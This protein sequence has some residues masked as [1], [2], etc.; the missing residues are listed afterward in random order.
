MRVHSEFQLAVIA[1]KE[2]CIYTGVQTKKGRGVKMV[3][4]LPTLYPDYRC[5]V[6]L[7]AAPG[8]PTGNY[9]IASC[10]LH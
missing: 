4:N 8:M 7:T 10:Q 3:V 1:T 9:H 6:M 5:P 2:W